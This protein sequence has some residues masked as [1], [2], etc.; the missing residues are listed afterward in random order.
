[1]FKMAS[2]KNA[3]NSQEIAK[4]LNELTNFDFLI[5]DNENVITQQKKRS[6]EIMTANHT[7]SFS[8]GT[9]YPQISTFGKKH[10]Q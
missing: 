5:E 4:T 10:A 9:A 8:S 2:R 1:M 7:I 6:Q 3:G